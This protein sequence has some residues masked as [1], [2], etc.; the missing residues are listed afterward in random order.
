MTEPIHDNIKQSMRAAE[1]LYH[2][3]VLLVG[4]SGHGKTAILRELAEELAVPLVNVNLALCGEMLELTAKQRPLQCQAIFRRV[5]ERSPPP[6]LLDNTEV[7]FDKALG[8]D[9]LRLLKSV[10]RNRLVVASWRGAF[11][12]KKLRYAEAGHRE[13][14]SD[15]P[16][17]ALIVAAPKTAAS[18]AAD[19]NTGPT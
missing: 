9:P 16:D 19:K 8:Q 12:G 7:L 5:A 4:E 1:G 2:R 17:G 11:D 14:R 13:Y 6:T 10:S 3:L 15:D 18:A